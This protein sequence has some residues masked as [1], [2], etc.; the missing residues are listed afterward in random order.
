MA[1]EKEYDINPKTFRGR[2]IGRKIAKILRQQ[3]KFVPEDTVILAVR[4]EKLILLGHG[5]EE[6]LDLEED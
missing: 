4:G 5:I 2:R 1:E 6:D 3:A